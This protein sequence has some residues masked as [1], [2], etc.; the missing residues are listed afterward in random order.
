[1]K[2]VHVFVLL[3]AAL[4]LAGLALAPF[5]A[6]T[7]LFYVVPLILVVCLIVWVLGKAAPILLD[8]H[9]HRD[10][11]VDIPAKPPARMCLLREGN[12]FVS[13]CARLS[14]A[15]LGWEP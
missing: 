12:T 14:F 6:M 9:K 8:C 4:M 2:T 10:R 7:A 1:M 5:H 13:I 15:L 3:T 11:L